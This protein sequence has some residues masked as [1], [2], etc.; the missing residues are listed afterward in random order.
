[1]TCGCK[2]NP[3][4]EAAIVDADFEIDALTSAP[5]TPARRDPILRYVYKICP[6]IY[7]PF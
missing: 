6:A 4:T 2:P 7:R 1:M 3:D 5:I